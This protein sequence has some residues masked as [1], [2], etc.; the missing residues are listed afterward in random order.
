MGCP[1]CESTTPSE[2]FRDRTRTYVRCRGCDLIFVPYEY[3]LSPDK[4]NRRYDLH[5]N[6]PAD[7]EY[8]NFLNHLVESLSARLKPGSVGLDFGAGPG[9]ALSVMMR[10]RGFEMMDYDPIYA[11]D[12]GLLERKYDFVAC[13]E[14]VEHFKRPA[15]SWELL[16]GLVRPGGTIGI[17]TE[18]FEEGMDF[19]RWRYIRDETHVAFYSRGT[20]EWIAKNFD[21]EVQFHGRSV[22]ILTE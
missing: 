6:S 12:P 1:L 8:R 10:E 17:M 11:C 21:L 3:H 22:V 13:S 16:V 4:E 19:S 9:P 7:P 14:T 15:E 20:F 5:E 18:I 2:F